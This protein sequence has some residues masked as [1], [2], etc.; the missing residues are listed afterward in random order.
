MIL[1]PTQ[2][3]TCLWEEVKAEVEALDPV[4]FQSIEAFGPTSKHTLFKARYPYGA[5]IL[6][7]GVFASGES[8]P[9]VL[10]LKKNLE[11]YLNYQ[12]VSVSPFGVLKPGTLLGKSTE[13]HALWNLSSGARSLFILPKIAESGG[14]GK[15]QK[16]FSLGAPKPVALRDHWE[17]FRELVNHPECSAN[18][19]SEVLF[20]GET[21]S[22]WTP[23]T[24][25]QPP[26]WTRNQFAWDLIFSTFQIEKLTKVN[27]YIIDV[28]KHLI[29]IGMGAQ[30]GFSPAC[31][32]ENAPIST[33]Q[34][35]FV[36]IYRVDYAPVFLTSA[37]FTEQAVYYSPEYL[38]GTTFSLNSRRLSPKIADL[39]E[40]KGLLKK[41][42]NYVKNTQTG[43]HKT[44]LLELASNVQYDFFHSHYED[45]MEIYPVDKLLE[46]DLRFVQGAGQS[47]LPLPVNSSF[48]NGC[49]RVSRRATPSSPCVAA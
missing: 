46:E 17:V 36:D 29:N 38:T 3:E 43:V 34:D 8:Y 44:A 41:F 39:Y 19:S 21:W 10:V 45:Y 33:L 13:P 18:W 31:D 27:P 26:V 25:W 4:L 15:L 11:F 22:E 5:E 12:S 23:P 6:K 14:F 28:M 20:F 1:K 9:F 48:L 37:C 47:S 24:A 16:K 30:A 42:F 40:I 7:N 49:V 32:N 2:Y 35:I